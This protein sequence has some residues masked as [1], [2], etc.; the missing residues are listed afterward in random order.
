MTRRS[1]IV[2][3]LAAALGLAVGVAGEERFPAR[4]G[5]VVIRPLAHASVRVDYRD[6]VVYVDPWSRANL[7]GA[8]PADLI[9]VTDADAGAHHL[10]AA[11]IQQLRTSGTVILMPA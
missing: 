5:D 9:L 3:T 8:P 7:A 6:L 11:A 1:G 4:A 2:A 10:D